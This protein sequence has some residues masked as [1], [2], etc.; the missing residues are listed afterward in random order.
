[1]DEATRTLS[2]FPI[3]LQGLPAG[4]VMTESR[5]LARNAVREQWRAE[6]RKVL[7]VPYSELVKAAGA[8]LDMHRAEL[9]SQARENLRKWSVWFPT[10]KQTLTE[11]RERRLQEYR[12]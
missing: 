9:V 2:E 10:K 12:R 8:Y 1:M 5:R 6:G 7:W 4:A 3:P 11:R